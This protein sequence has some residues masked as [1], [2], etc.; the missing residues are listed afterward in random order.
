MES[1]EFFYNKMFDDY[2]H[3]RHAIKLCIKIVDNKKIAIPNLEVKVIPLNTTLKTNQDGIINIVY[4]KSWVKIG[5]H[6]IKY[7]I[8][9]LYLTDPLYYEV[10]LNELYC[11]EHEVNKHIRLSVYK[12]GIWVFNESVQTFRAYLNSEPIATGRIKPYLLSNKDLFSELT[13]IEYSIYS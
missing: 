7:E 4:P 13:R 12:Y 9:E 6:N 2:C 10:Q 5:F 3:F 1:N 11:R 8:A